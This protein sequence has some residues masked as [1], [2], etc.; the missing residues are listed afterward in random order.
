MRRSFLT[1]AEVNA[2]GY[3][4]ECINICDALNAFGLIFQSITSRRASV[5]ERLFLLGTKQLA[6]LWKSG[7]RLTDVMAGLLDGM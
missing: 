7:G 3:K 1:L 6:F 5:T 2:L 4:R